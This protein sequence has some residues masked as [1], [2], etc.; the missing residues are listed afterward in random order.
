MK[1]ME[2]STRELVK[3]KASSK[4]SIFSCSKCSRDFYARVGP[5]CHSLGMTVHGTS[6][7]FT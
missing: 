1:G 7:V 3:K 4:T 5:H 6:I 2:K